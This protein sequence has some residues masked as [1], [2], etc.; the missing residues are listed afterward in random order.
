V[1]LLRL[2]QQHRN[3]Y[4]SPSGFLMDVEKAFKF[5]TKM[6]AEKHRQQLEFD[7]FIS[8]SH[9]YDDTIFTPISFDYQF[10]EHEKNINW[11]YYEVMKIGKTLVVQSSVSDDFISSYVLP[12]AVYLT[13]KGYCSLKTF[14]KNADKVMKQKRY[15]SM[16]YRQEIL[17][18]HNTLKKV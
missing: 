17:E 2:K 5:K 9:Y 11:F 14:L 6:D 12:E 16:R 7:A 1:W 15:Y 10:P 8:V 4:L 18:Y 3:F 13:S